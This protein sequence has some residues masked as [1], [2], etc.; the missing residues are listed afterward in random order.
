MSDQGLIE[1]SRRGLIPT[2]KKEDDDHC[3]PYIYRKQHKV[4]FANSSKRSE[5]VLELVYSD[6]WGPT[7][8]VAWGGDRYFVTFTDDFS[9]RV[10]MYLI[11]KKSEVV[12][13]FK[14]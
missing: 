10:W 1:L 14:I 11:K 12:V 6:I 8:I 4:K 13:R 7:P 3:E 2:L 5:A 9:M